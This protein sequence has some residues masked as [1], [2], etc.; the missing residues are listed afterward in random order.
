[1]DT[2]KTTLQVTQRVVKL[3]VTASNEEELVRC[4]LPSLPCHPRAALTL[5]EGLALWSG[6]PLCVATFVA[7]DCP[8]I[9]F[10]DS[11]FGDVAGSSALVRHELMSSRSRPRRLRG[12]GDFRDLLRLHGRGW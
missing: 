9:W 6:K 4:R 2:W 11:P 12:V 5:L 1:M 8:P 3:L 10:D 7:D